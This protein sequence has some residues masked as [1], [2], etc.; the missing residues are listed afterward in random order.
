M[1]RHVY[2]AW[3]TAI[4]LVLGGC[5]HLSVVVPP[6]A[7]PCMRACEGPFQ[8]CELDCAVFEGEPFTFC[9][10]GCNRDKYDCALACPGT[11][12]GFSEIPYDVQQVYLPEQTPTPQFPGS[13]PPELLRP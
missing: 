5:L 10:K 6:S 11:V 1:R 13:L 2:F 9:H 7:W 12:R 8:R 4:V 3:I